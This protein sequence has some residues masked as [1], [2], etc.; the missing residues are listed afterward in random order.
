VFEH[1]VDDELHPSQRGQRECV[2]EVSDEAE[3]A[4]AAA[5]GEVERGDESRGKDVRGGTSWVKADVGMTSRF[6][7]LARTMAAVPQPATAAMR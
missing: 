1:Q 2:Q 4:R 7:A 3:G 5:E 6:A